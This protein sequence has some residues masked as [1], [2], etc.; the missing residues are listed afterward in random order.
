MTKLDEAFGVYVHWPFC[1]AKCPYCDFNSH[2]RHNPVDQELFVE[3]YVREIAH[4][5]SIVPN[6]TVTSIFFGGGTP[7]LMEPKTLEKILAEISKNWTVASEVEISLE[8]NPQSVDA[9]RFQAYAKA[10]VNR[11]SLGV[12]SFNDE[13]LKFLG[14]LHNADEA[15]QAIAIAQKHFPRMSFD[16][17]YARPDQTSKQ[18]EEEL[19]A[20]IALAADHL[21]LYQLTIEHG[22]PFYNLHERGKLKTPRDEQ[23]AELYELTQSICTSNGFETYEIS[24]HAKPGAQCQH[25]L[26]Y[27][28]GQ[29]YAGI[30]PGA[31][32]RLTISKGRVATATQPNPEKWWQAANVD[33]HGLTELEVLSPEEHADELMIMGLRLAEGFDPIRYEAVSGKSLNE[34]EVSFLQEMEMVSFTDNGLMRVTPKGFL[35]LDA[36]VADLAIEAQ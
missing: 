9:D 36:I 12:Q 16:M 30:G 3:G 29:D 23:A 27:W 32:G 24:N 14:R 33:G 10:G 1:A 5:A 22:T 8:A 13:Q 11:V 15:K 34:K 31:H 19:S 25:N 6:K 4:M 35:L 2:V 26:V 17:I 18:W 20:A 28:R 7:S 21:S